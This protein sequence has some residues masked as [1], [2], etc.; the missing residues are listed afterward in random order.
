MHNVSQSDSSTLTWAVCTTP[1]CELWDGV[2]VVLAAEECVIILP[3]AAWW[4]HPHDLCA[5]GTL[6]LLFSAQ[7]SIK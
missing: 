7:T 6:N 3:S 5:A 4:E 2:K 1:S